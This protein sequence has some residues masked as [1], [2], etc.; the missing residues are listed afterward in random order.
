[1]SKELQQHETAVPDTAEAFPNV[2]ADTHMIQEL[3]QQKV[4]SD[5]FLYPDDVLRQRM[6]EYKAY[7]QRDDISPRSRAEAYK[8]MRHVGFELLYRGGYFESAPDDLSE[9]L[10]MLTGGS[11]E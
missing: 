2:Y 3:S 8:V 4:A 1:M 10:D 9:V 5:E 11:D 6:V 7:V